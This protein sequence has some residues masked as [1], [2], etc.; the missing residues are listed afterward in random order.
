M[1]GRNF[2]NKKRTKEA[3][4]SIVFT[5]FSYTFFIVIRNNLKGD[6]SSLNHVVFLAYFM[7]FCVPFMVLS[8]IAGIRGFNSEND[9]LRALSAL[10]LI[11]TAMLFSWA[12]FFYLGFKL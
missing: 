7:F 6:A 11:L 2:T 9:M 4:Q 12:L 10:G 5:V 1:T 3:I 8:I